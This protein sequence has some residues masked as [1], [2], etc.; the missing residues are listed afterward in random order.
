RP[1]ATFRSLKSWSNS[2]NHY[3]YC[4]TVLRTMISLALVSAAGLYSAK[5]HPGDSGV[6]GAVGK[7]VTA[8]QLGAKR[9]ARDVKVVNLNDVRGSVHNNTAIDV[10]TGSN[11]ITNGSFAGTTGFPMVIQNTGNNVLIQSS[12]IL[13]I[14][15]QP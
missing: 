10:V 9:G 12:M 3:Q 13:N 4:D 5:V 1:A 8:Q 15:L 11:A 14:G 7:P 6:L 2:M